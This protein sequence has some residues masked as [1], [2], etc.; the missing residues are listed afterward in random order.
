MKRVGSLFEKAFTK[1]NIL[2]AFYDASKHKKSRRGCFEFERCLGSN[3][4]ALHKE[5]HN[6]TYK[7]CRYYTFTVYE[8]KK[9][10]IYAPA[11]RDCVVQHAIYR[12]VTPVFDATFIDQ[13]F[14]CRKGLGTHKAADYAQKALQITDKNSYF[15]KLDIR[16]F[17]YRIDRLI[18]K[19]L[20]EKKIKDQRM[21]NVMM[22]FTDHGEKLG[23]P[24]GN[25]LS[26]LYALIYLNPLDH[27]IKRV[28]K[29]KHY[30]RYVDDFVLF[31]ISKQSAIDYLAKLILFLKNTLNLELSKSTIL[32][33]RKGINF[34][35]YRTWSSKRFI[36]KRSLYNYKVA[37]KNYKIESIVSI[38]G[39]ARYTHSLKYLLTLLKEHNN[40][41]NLCL[42]K[43]YNS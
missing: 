14:A 6:G 38:L 11:F 10:Q 32:K 12:V 35:G 25:L 34:V 21:V 5:L 13:S 23:I 1:E 42:P 9:R 28:L 7:P 37:I 41:Q 30:C 2:A 22:L 31:G 17:F 20:F 18:L 40:A 15:L 27:Y 26:Q 36:R 3:I 29:I 16:K 43:V 8:P 24:I 4:T 19:S 39:H 33:N